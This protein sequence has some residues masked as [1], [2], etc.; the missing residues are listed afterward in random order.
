MAYRHAYY[1]WLL[2]RSRGKGVCSLQTISERVTYGGTKGY[3]KNM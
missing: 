1:T 2:L 3:K